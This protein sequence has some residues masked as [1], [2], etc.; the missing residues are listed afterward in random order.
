[1]AHNCKELD[2]L[3]KKAENNQFRIN[4][5]NAVTFQAIHSNK[6]VQIFTGHFSER[7]LHPFRRFLKNIAKVTWL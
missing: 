1:M 3:I 5:R 6:E 4:W 2:K 7:G